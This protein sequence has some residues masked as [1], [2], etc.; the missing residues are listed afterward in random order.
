MHKELAVGHKATSD[1]DSLAQADTKLS[2]MSSVTPLGCS[3]S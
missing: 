1:I 3:M 2:S